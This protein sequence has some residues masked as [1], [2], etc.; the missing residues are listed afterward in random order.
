MHTK[1]KKGKKEKSQL[2]RKLTKT[3]VQTKSHI[4]VV[5]L[6]NLAAAGVI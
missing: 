1:H 5:E 4:E 2:V 3:H 6:E